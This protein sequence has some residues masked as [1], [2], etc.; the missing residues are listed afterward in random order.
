MYVFLRVRSYVRTLDTFVRVYE[1]DGGG[2]I[3]VNEVVSLVRGW[4]VHI[5]GLAYIRFVYLVTYN[6]TIYNSC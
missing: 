2:G 1:E 3:E 4:Q 6:S 5:D